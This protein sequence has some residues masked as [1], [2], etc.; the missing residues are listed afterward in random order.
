MKNIPKSD[1][2]L[3]N[4]PQND[5]NEF[6]KEKYLLFSTRLST[7]TVKKEDRRCGGL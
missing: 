6:F 1:H 3:C 2:K 4:F 7:D 5:L